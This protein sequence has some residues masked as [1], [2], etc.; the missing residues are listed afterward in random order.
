MAVSAGQSSSA[1]LVLVN[2]ASLIRR[3]SFAAPGGSPSNTRSATI[4]WL[5][6]A[7][8][9]TTAGFGG[10]GSGLAYRS[11]SAHAAASERHAMNRRSHRGCLSRGR[12]LAPLKPVR[13]KRHRTIG[14]R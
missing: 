10:I 4:L 12:F 14:N 2:R 7:T 5:G 11:S 1:M 6:A 3:R 13:T 9:A 8:T